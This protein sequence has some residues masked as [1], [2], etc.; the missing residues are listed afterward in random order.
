MATWFNKPMIGGSPAMVVLQD[1]IRK[2]APADSTILIEGESGTGKEL[3]ARA[4]HSYSNRSGRP[5][6]AINC[7]NL[8]EHLLESDLFGHERGSFTGAD[9]RRIGKFELAA[10]GTLF[11]DE[12][13]E[14]GASVQGRL[15]RAIQERVIDRVGGAHP[16]PVDIRIIAATNRELRDEVQAR[17]FREDLYYRLN[18]VSIK[19]PPLRERPEDILALALHF[20][21]HYGSK[22]HRRVD[23]ISDAAQQILTNYSWPG[24]VRQLENVVERAVVMGGASEVLPEDLPDELRAAEEPQPRFT[25]ILRDTECRLIEGAFRRFGDYKRAAEWLGI[26]PQGIH[27]RLRALGLRHLLIR[28]FPA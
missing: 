17:R 14:L 5:F 27:R 13:G 18:V 1:F 16:I 26:N 11:L 15:L 21:D 25:Q 24:N 4:L 8:S 9:A 7:A 6:V 23:G 2:A 12:I 10:G 20:L 19:T 3:V 22:S 28:P